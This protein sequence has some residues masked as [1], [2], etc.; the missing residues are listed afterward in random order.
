MA[1]LGYATLAV[2]IVL[3][4]V[5][6]YRFVERRRLGAHHHIERIQ[7]HVAWAR[8]Y[9]RYL[10]NGGEL[11]RDGVFGEAPALRIAAFEAVGRK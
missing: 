10:W 4:C 8:G 2:T 9:P 6:Y 5:A 11:V 1:G 7:G 3:V